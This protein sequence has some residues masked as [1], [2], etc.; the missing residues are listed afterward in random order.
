MDLEH[1]SPFTTVWIAGSVCL[2]LLEH[3]GFVSEHQLFFSTYY[4]FKRH[5][6]W[7]FIT[8]FMYFGRF[9]LMFALRMLDLVRFAYPLEA[10]TFGPTRQAQFAWLLLCASIVLLLLSPVLSIHYL[11][12][13]LSWTMV[14]IWSRKNRHIRVSFFGLVVMNAPYMPYFELLFTLLQKSQEVKDIVLGLSLGHLCTLMPLLHF[15]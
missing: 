14:Y 9:G 7:R 1:L 15:F 10:Q 11:S 13:P 8:T 5:Q 12:V 2:T 6:Y 3:L 4:I